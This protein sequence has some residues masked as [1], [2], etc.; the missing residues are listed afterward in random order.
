MESLNVLVDMGQFATVT[1]SNQQDHAQF[2]ALVVTDML[3]RLISCCIIINVEGVCKTSGRLR[4]LK[5][6]WSLTA[7]QHKKAVLCHAK[8]KNLLKKHQNSPYEL[9]CLKLNGYSLT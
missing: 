1:R 3:W 7:F 2:G 5:V 4:T 8:I 9:F 6:G